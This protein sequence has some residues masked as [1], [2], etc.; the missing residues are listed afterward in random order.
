MAGLVAGL[1]VVRTDRAAGLTG[2][3]AWPH[4]PAAAAGAAGAV[5]GAAM[6]LLA[7]L[8]GGAAGPGR[9]AVVGPAPGWVG[10]AVAVEVGTAAALTIWAARRMR[11]A[12][13]AGL[14][15]RVRDR[16]RRVSRW[17]P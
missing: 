1:L 11:S 7:W 8:A 3:P 13:P 17:F 5:A 10:L 2:R 12:G 4:H 16:L 9:M 15:A 6:A 14:P